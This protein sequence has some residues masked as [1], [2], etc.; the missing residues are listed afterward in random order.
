[1]YLFSD[2]EIE[3]LVKVEGLKLVKELKFE[4]S[5]YFGYNNKRGSG[6]CESDK[7][8]FVGECFIFM[9]I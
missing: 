5:Y 2:W 7:Y 1:M 6:G 9:F 3:R 8:F 4:W